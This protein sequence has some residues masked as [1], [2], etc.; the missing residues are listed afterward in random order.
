M[1]F[2]S[3]RLSIRLAGHTTTL[4]EAVLMPPADARRGV[5]SDKG[6]GPPFSFG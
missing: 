1:V 6:F 2:L 5:G 3:G 4:G